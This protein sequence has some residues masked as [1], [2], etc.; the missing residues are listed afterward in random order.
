MA[1]GYGP[2]FFQPVSQ[3]VRKRHSQK[4][5]KLLASSRSKPTSYDLYEQ[6]VHQSQISLNE[7]RSAFCFFGTF[8]FLEGLFILLNRLIK[9]E[10]Y[11]FGLVRVALQSS[12]LCQCLV[13]L[14]TDVGSSKFRSCLSLV[15]H[16]RKDVGAVA[17]QTI[18]LEFPLS[19]RSFWAL[20]A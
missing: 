6:R 1:G 15:G 3:F 13:F 11:E 19:S 20:A 5:M 9:K 16:V 8:W 17:G 7:T 4:H 10:T 2:V 18:M 14:Y 12:N